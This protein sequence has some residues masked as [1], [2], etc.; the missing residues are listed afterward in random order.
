MQ[1]TKLSAR[2]Q[3]W[4]G[5]AMLHEAGHATFSASRLVEEVER[6]FGATSST[7][8]THVNARCVA[9]AP[10]NHGVAYSYLTRTPEG[11][12]LFRAGD[13]V[14]PSKSGSATY[15]QQTEVPEEHWELWRRWAPEAQ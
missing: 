11:F 12:R 1:T 10:K 3:V 4:L 13:P 2:I 8:T 9:S 14:H 5:A 6:R 15:P 7:V